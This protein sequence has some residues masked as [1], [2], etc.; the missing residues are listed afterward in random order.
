MRKSIVTLFWLAVACASIAALEKG[1]AEVFQPVRDILLRLHLSSDDFRSLADRGVIVRPL[2]S[3]SVKEMA[4]FGV[5]MADA[6]PGRF[7]EAYKT[8]A[9]FQNNPC[10]TEMGVFSSVPRLSDLDALTV[11]P[12]DVFELSRARPGDSDIKLSTGELERIQKLTA[13]GTRQ[14][15]NKAQIAQEY[16]RILLDRLTAYLRSGDQG[17]GPY[18]DKSEP[19]RPD[20]AFKALADEQSSESGSARIVCEYLKSYP[21]TQ[22]PNSESVVYWAKE[23][24]H[25]LKSVI[26]LVH[27]LIHRDG[28]RIFIA[29]KQIYSSHYNEAGLSLA[30][31]IPFADD[32]GRTHT[33]IVYTIRLEPD[34]LGGALGFMKKRMAMPKM[35][36]TLR[37]SLARIRD[38][39][40]SSKSS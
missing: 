15:L 3:R 21:V 6:S 36:V 34:M 37:D 1:D 23:K 26:T 29:S 16:K 24:F 8:L 31:L 7:V 18:I 12:I 28:G 2:H 27:L 4:A 5:V 20:Q 25:E 14:G 40:E 19:V 17:M 9:V 35:Q 39:L 32:S 30:E 10:I 33:V 13:S 22:L 11:E 38:N